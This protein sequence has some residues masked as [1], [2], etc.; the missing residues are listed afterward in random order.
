M[1]VHV[2]PADTLSLGATV[3]FYSKETGAASGL[4]PSL[5]LFTPS[6][7]SPPT[8]VTMQAALSVS[9]YSSLSAGQQAR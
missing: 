5:L 8:S 4:G 7:L 9:G 2:R 3:S 1:S 6:A